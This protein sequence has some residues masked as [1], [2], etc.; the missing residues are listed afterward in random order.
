[1]A[2]QAPITRKVQ[3]LGASSLIVTLPRDWARRHN[4]N[5]GETVFMYD[6]GDKLVISPRN[7]WGPA[8]LRFLLHGSHLVKHLGKLCLCSY[9]FG[10]DNLYLSSSH[11]LKSQLIER[12]KGAL[13]HVDVDVESFDGYNLKI[14]FEPAAGD[15]AQL[16]VIL[17]RAVGSF[18][19][20]IAMAL[21]AGE[22]RWEE[23]NELYDEIMAFNYRLL[24][25]SVV[26]RTTGVVETRLY[27]ILQSVA[28]VMGLLADASYKM[29]LDL[30]TLKDRLTEDEKERINFI[31]QIL[32][33]AITTT[34]TSIEP[35]S[36][37]KAEEAYWKIKQVLD[38]EGNLA[39]VIEGSSPAFAYLLG[40]AIDMAR[41]AEVAETA[42]L[43]YTLIKK[44]NVVLEPE[45]NGRRRNGRR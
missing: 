42:L 34:A 31:L 3:R 15:P 7:G 40:K 13:S 44:Y 19:G 39:D 17:G 26:W 9:L 4:I 32:E 36:V 11:P 23:F 38:L 35:P 33:V 5:V 21:K 8:E 2:V 28:S 24:R 45:R 16:I 1:M 6:E 43:C 10:F 20:R 25:S 29:A 27:R 41:L 37:K 22:Y 30:R 12:M 14:R 18:I